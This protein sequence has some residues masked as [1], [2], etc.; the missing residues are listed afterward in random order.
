MSTR[1]RTADKRQRELAMQAK[2][3]AK[4][5]RR[6]DRSSDADATSS[7]QAGDDP[8]TEQL[9]AQIESLHARFDEGTIPFEEFDEQKSELLDR[10]A[11]KLASDAS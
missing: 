3:A 5:E 11:V 2:A 7:G 6:Q 4:R 1:R 9:L 8:T 10:M